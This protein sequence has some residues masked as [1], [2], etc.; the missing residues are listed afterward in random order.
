MGWKV[1]CSHHCH[2]KQCDDGNIFFGY[3]CVKCQLSINRVESNV[4]VIDGCCSL[5]LVD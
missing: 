5:G 2:V 3:L 4:N 1:F